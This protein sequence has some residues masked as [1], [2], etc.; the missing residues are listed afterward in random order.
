VNLFFYNPINLN[1][2]NK[3]YST[4]AALAVFTTG[5]LLAQ[6]A[7]ALTNGLEGTASAYDCSYEV[8][9]ANQTILLN[10]ST[11]TQIFTACTD[12]KLMEVTLNIKALNDR[13][14]YTVEVRSMNGL[15][16]DIARFKKG[17]VVD[18][19]VVLP[20]ETHVKSGLR[21]ILNV[22]S[23]NGFELSIRAKHGPMGTLTIDG[24]PYRGKLVGEFGFKTVEATGLSNDEG[25]AGQTNDDVTF[26]PTDKSAN[27]LCYNSV[28]DHTG[29]IATSGETIGQTFTACATGTLKQISYQIQHIDADFVGRISVKDARNNTLF[30]QDVSARNV[31]NGE[32]V[33]PMSE[34]VREGAEYKIVLKSIRGTRLAVLANDNPADALGTCTFNGTELETNACFSALVKENRNNTPSAFSETDLKV[35]AYPNPFEN[36]LGIRI[37]G[38]EEGKVIVQLLDFAGNVLRADMINVNPDNKVINFNTDD[39]NDVGF[40]SLR[41]VHGDEV[42]H[43]TVIKH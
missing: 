8:K 22:S 37:D 12:G 7:S 15:V 10:G 11:A 41:V 30:I 1:I 23:D 20:M 29:R 25:R 2:M 21:Y 43:T 24:S 18:G 17:Q 39:L 32:L 28:S 19:K 26:I 36:E 13:G 42:T 27:G 31:R 6:D 35:T 9:D 14:T 5:N 16:L 33:V 38:I 34:K 40:Y 3:F 4:L